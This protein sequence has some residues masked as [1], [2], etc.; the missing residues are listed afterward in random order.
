MSANRKA[1]IESAINLSINNADEK[2]KANYFNLAYIFCRNHPHFHGGKFCEF[3]R[4]RNL[5]EPDTHNRWV[6]M[7][8]Q[9]ERDGLI[10]RLGD[11]EPDT[12]QSHMNEIGYWESTVYKPIR[13]TTEDLAILEELKK[14]D[15]KW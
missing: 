6:G 7:V 9:L 12:V 3:A 5:W 13:Y 15:D 4:S 1:V 10:R 11:A 14:N 8:K 2:W